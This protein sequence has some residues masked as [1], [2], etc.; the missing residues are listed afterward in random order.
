MRCPV[1][2]HGTA[3]LLEF[4]SWTW[5]V[6]RL[7]PSEGAGSCPMRIPGMNDGSYSSRH[8]L[9]GLV[10]GCGAVLFDAVAID[11]GSSARCGNAAVVPVYGNTLKS[12]TESFGATRR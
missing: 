11:H 1:L 9:E 7:W 12:R 4:S 2:L 8:A 5:L 3:A 6:P 10:V